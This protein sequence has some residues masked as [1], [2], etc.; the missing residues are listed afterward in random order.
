ME[1]KN[2]V[3][4]LSL[5][6]TQLE[7]NYELLLAFQQAAFNSNL[8]SYIPLY[9]HTGTPPQKF[10]L[11]IDTGSSN[12]WVTNKD[13]VQ[14]KDSEGYDHNKSST[15]REDG[16][17]FSVEYGDGGIEGWVSRDLVRVETSG[18][19]LQGSRC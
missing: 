17:E 10:N 1:L 7:N 16:G 4:N 3:F 8:S 6:S 13:C 9:L 19:T 2:G 11:I 5:V 15:Y 18:E 14:L 12:L